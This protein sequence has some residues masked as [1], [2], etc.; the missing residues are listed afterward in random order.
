MFKLFNESCNLI[1][2]DGLWNRH[3][4]GWLEEIPQI[5]PLKTLFFAWMLREHRK[6][7]TRKH[8]PPPK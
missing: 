7:A 4:M 6:K 5:C 1:Q 2:A 8:R 3:I